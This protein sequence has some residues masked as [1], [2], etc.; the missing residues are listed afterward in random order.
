MRSLPLDTKIIAF[1]Y[2]AQALSF[3]AVLICLLSAWLLHDSGSQA[4]THDAEVLTANFSE[5][6]NTNFP[7]KPVTI[8]GNFLL[9][10]TSSS[11]KVIKKA[12]EYINEF[13]PINALN[14]KSSLQFQDG[15]S[16]MSIESK[17]STSSM[18]G[19]MPYLTEK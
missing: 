15:L 6:K 4:G 11:N 2:W 10:E 17:L 7:S 13:L 5:R 12:S 16:M 1:P 18:S 9:V 3:A 14:S 19:I 8:K